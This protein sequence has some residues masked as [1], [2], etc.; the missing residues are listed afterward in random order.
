M[1]ELNI[2]DL[3]SKYGFPIVTKGFE[4]LTGLNLVENA[5]LN[6]AYFSCNFSQNNTPLVP[7]AIGKFSVGIKVKSIADIFKAN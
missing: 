5:D 2:V 4:Y 3:V 7:T 6:E 1:E